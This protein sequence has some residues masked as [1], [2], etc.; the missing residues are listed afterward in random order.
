MLELNPE[1]KIREPGRS[2]LPLGAGLELE[3]GRL[4]RSAGSLGG[5]LVESVELQLGIN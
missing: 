3:G 5:D 2:N 4:W 1:K